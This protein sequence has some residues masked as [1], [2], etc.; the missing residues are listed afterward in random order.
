MSCGHLLAIVYQSLSF[1]TGFGATRRLRTQSAGLG[2]NLYSRD[3]RPYAQNDNRHDL[4][5]TQRIE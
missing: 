3:G 4:R 2:A 1:A 5:V